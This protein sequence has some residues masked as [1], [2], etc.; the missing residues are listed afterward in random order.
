MHKI[1]TIL[2]C[3]FCLTCL[4][5]FFSLRWPPEED[6]RYCMST[7]KKRLDSFHYIFIPFHPFFPSICLYLLRNFLSS[8]H[9]SSCRGPLVYIILFILMIEMHITKLVVWNREWKMQKVGV[10]SEPRHSTDFRTI[11]EIMIG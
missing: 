2:R 4:A 7:Q 6:F 5:L 1:N 8:V 9:A 11:F 10:D 3:V